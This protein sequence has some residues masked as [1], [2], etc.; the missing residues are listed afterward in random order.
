M[1]DISMA[2]WKRAPWL[3]L[4]IAGAAALAGIMIP[5][6][7]DTPAQPALAGT[8]LPPVPAPGFQLTD[9][10]G[11]YVSLAQFRGRT[12]VLTFMG[13]HCTELCPVVAEKIRRV[14]AALGPAG[15]N[16]VLLVI[17]T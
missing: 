7:N 10:F 4:V 14:V 17:S 8:T 2:V 13:A 16:V 11:H 9:Q 6:G 15:K 1:R 5:R 12:V 3:I